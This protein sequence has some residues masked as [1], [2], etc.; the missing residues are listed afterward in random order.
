MKPFDIK[1]RDDIE[2]GRLTVVTR[3]H[4]PVE[5]VRWDLRRDDC[6]LFIVTYNSGT[7][8]VMTC[9]ENGRQMFN[10]DTLYDLFIKEL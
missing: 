9:L 3:N 2:A 7:Q 5:I 4:L 6:I 8:A 1:Y 10:A